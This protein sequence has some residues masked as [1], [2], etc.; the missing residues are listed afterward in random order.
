MI[1]A[2]E[3]KLV[4]TT[5]P[6]LGKQLAPFDFEKMGDEA[7]MIANVLFKKMQ[8]LGGIGLSACQVGV[9]MR[10]FV[11]GVDD[12]KMYVFNP[13]IVRY[14]DDTDHAL[15][16][17]LSF[18]GLSLGINRS[19]TID[20]RYQTEKGETVNLTLGGITARVF[21]HEYDHMNGKLFTSHVTPFKL[22]YYKKKR[23]NK[24]AKLV[25]KYTQKI[26]K[27]IAND[28]TQRHVG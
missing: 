27:D 23:D 11:M 13:E 9:D 28:N 4:S 5:D 19:T 14:G 21:Q 6:I 15:E 17:C 2:S 1:K 7:G 24:Q 16:G 12:Y 26:L 8:D 10:L 20:V 22:Q 3:L 18:P 25:R